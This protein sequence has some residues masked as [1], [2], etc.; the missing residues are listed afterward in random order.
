MGHPV[1]PSSMVPFKSL[2]TALLKSMVM[3][4]CVGEWCLFLDKAW[5]VHVDAA[6]K[7]W[8]NFEAFDQLNKLILFLSRG[9]VLRSNLPRAT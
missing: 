5:N 6:A 4:W 1:D 9:R 2:L 8:L 7:L 3:A